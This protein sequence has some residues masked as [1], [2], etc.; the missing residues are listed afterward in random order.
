MTAYAF[1]IKTPGLV[2]ELD[3]RCFL[4]KHD[5]KA[6]NPQAYNPSAGQAGT[7]EFLQFA[8]QQT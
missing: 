1:E 5:F 2:G 8:G 4:F 7:G 3:W 6:Q